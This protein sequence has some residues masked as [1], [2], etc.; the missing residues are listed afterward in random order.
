MDSLI[1][2]KMPISII[3]L[4][5][6]GLPLACV[7]AEKNFTVNGIDIDQNKVTLINQGIC[8]LQDAD[9]QESFSK[10]KLSAATNF[11]AI[12]ESDIVV[13]CVPTPIDGHHNPD[14]KPLENACRGIRPNLRKNHLIILESTVNPGACEEVVQ[15]I[16]EKS[17]LKAG[18]DF[19]IAHC[20][21]R[22]DPGNHNW[23]V[24]KIPRVVGATTPAGL[25]RALSFYRSVIDAN[26]LPMA[27]IKEAEATKIMENAFRDVNIAFVNEL[28]ESFS[29]LGIDITRVIK[30][31]STKPFSFLAHY[32]GCG[33]GGHCIPV[34]PYY[35]IRQA[36]KNGFKHR[37]LKVAREINEGM[38]AYTVHLLEEELM[39]LHKTI[40]DSSIGVL[41][42]AF[43]SDVADT[44]ESP[45]TKI[46]KLLTE[47]G[48]RVHTFD[49]LVI[50]K[51]TEKSLEELLNKSEAVILAT[52]HRQFLNLDLAELKENN[53]KV[54]IDGRNCLDKEKIQQMGIAYRGIGR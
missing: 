40:K 34:D 33:V 11:K 36:K 17:G 12:K 48:A 53:V 3:G 39:K 30:A 19:D 26:I 54:F 5:Y 38:P 49:P 44:R 18:I 51:S 52:P 50:E 46:I 2:D 29:T 43:K 14:F 47:K 41:G 7:C 8:P 23:T 37:L 31:A 24:K 9:L 20:P 4:G 1:T 13:I 15:P 27:S 6:V 25:Q 28:A 32:P 10:I 21:E 45:A 42:I 22:I 35:L 16:L